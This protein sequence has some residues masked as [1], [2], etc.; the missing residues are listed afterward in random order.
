MIEGSIIPKVLVVDHEPLIC[1]G[2]VRCLDS[3]AEVIAVTCAEEALVQLERE[4]FDV[5]LMDIFLPGM[6]GLNALRLINRKFPLIKVVIVTGHYLNDAIRDTINNE[7]YA[8][9]EK[10]FT[11]SQIRDLVIDAALPANQNF[12]NSSTAYMKR[13]I[14]VVE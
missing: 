13:N 8:L 4:N 7:A 2:I 9:I 11:V 6:D 10:P 1:A 3:R 12:F 5:C 14:T